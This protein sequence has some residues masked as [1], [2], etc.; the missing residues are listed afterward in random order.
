MFTFSMP[1]PVKAS[2]FSE[3]STEKIIIDINK[4][5][6]YKTLKLQNS[7]EKMRT[8]QNSPKS[9][10]ES[11]RGITDKKIIIFWAYLFLDPCFS[12]RPTVVDMC[13]H[14]EI[15]METHQPDS[16]KVE[17]WPLLISDWNAYSPYCMPHTYFEI[18]LSSTRLL[19]VEQQ[20]IKLDLAL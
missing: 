1:S 18:H 16:K 7:S 2:I 4:L 13:H 17:Y 14:F 9:H 10:L 6:H 8:H 11:T 19:T 15:R 12:G 3:W 20:P 5:Q